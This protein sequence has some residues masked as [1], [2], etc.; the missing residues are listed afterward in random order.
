MIRRDWFWIMLGAASAV[1]VAGRVR[2]AFLHDAGLALPLPGTAV[3][4]VTKHGDFGAYRAGPPVHT[5]QG[6]DLSAR[7]GSEVLAIGDG[8]IVPANPGLGKIVRKLKLDMPATWSAGGEPI[9]F[10]VYADL[11]VP[12]IDP[13]ERVCRGDA[14]ALVGPE[15][16]VHFAVKTKSLWGDETFIDPRKAGL[17]YRSRTESAPLVGLSTRETR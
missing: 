16:F 12:V 2:R 5:H 14:I 15:G 10:A 17:V 9:E 7:P 8:L 1:L 4:R 11:G 6:I 13:G 3:P